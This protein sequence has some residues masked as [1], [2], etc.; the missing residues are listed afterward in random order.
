MPGVIFDLDRK[1]KDI[2]E[3]EKKTHEPAFWQN[4][5][6]ANTTLKKLKRLKSGLGIW[7]KTQKEFEEY[8][9]LIELIQ[10]EDAESL[11]EIEEGVKKLAGE[12]EVIELSSLLGGE[13]DVSNAILNMH[14]GAGGT[15]SCD[16]VSMLVRMYNRWADSRGFRV[17][18][19]DVLP[20]EEAGIKNITMIM[21][22][23]YAYG[24]LK[25]EIGVHRLV[26]ISPF[27]A[28][29]RRHTSFAS[30]DVIP[31]IEDDIKVDINPADLKIDTYRAGGSGGQHVNVTDSAVRITHLPTGM[32]AQCQDERSQH[33]NK[34]MALK[35]LKARIYEFEK[36]KQKE[37]MEKAYEQKG[38]IA[39]GNQIRSY[40]FTPYTMVKDHRTGHTTGNVEAVMNGEINDFIWAYLKKEAPSRKNTN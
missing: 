8:S 26:R 40:V 1:I 2:S 17:K 6:I 14:A 34:A 33:K 30:V 7:Q 29:K 19:I 39:W 9:E 32:V 18:V 12:I 13:F 22:G 25:A 4:V 24:Y 38:D 28:N 20:G 16:W 37:K 31:E 10:E 15:E 35:V 11:I 36:N 5:E 3:L 21:E 27:D 23:D